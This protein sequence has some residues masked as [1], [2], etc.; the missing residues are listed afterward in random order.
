MIKWLHDNPVGWIL[1]ALCGL[2]LLMLLVLGLLSL[3]PLDTGSAGG[4]AD[5]GDPA[6]AVPQLGHSPPI[7][8]YEVITQRPLFNENR[9]PVLLEDATVDPLADALEDVNDEAPE[10]TLSGVV[11]T[12]SLR[13]VTFRRKGSPESLVAF[14]GQPI[15][16]EFSSWQVSR[17]DSRKATL[18]SGRGE[19]L[20]LELQVHD[21]AIKQPERPALRGEEKTTTAAAE[22]APD[23]SAEPLSRAEEIR[24][25]IAE[26]REELRRQAAEEDQAGEAAPPPSYQDAI[27]A[28]M[29]RGRRAAPKNENENQQ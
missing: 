18:T 22:P 11:I 21:Q 12:P 14:E 26:R 5:D 13:M 29:N 6:L 4:E 27:Q 23:A 25:R 24:Q 2:M 17:I 9:Q 19:E 16:G 20:Q 3:V 28:M 7:D 1:A 15:E 8:H 10:V